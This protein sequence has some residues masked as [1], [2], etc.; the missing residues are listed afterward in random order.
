[1]EIYALV[2][3]ND[4]VIGIIGENEKVSDYRQIRF[5]NAILFCQG[6]VIVPQRTMNKKLYPGCYDYSGGG[7]VNYGE[8][9]EEAII[10]EMKEELGIDITDLREIAYLNPYKDGVG[11][12]SKFFLAQYD[13]S[14]KIKYS[15]E[16]VE[17]ILLFSVDEIARMI[18]REP[19]MFKPDYIVAFKKYLI[20]FRNNS[21]PQ[22]KEGEHNEGNKDFF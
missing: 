5:A 12:F 14:Q 18:E 13:E 16:E 8:T 3:E 4:E 10:R 22:E 7:H 15:P 19:E 20:Q 2:N 21:Q 1:M 17:K 9:Y 11:C 6:K